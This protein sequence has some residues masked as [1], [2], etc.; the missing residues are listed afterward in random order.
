MRTHAHSTK[1]KKKYLGGAYKANSLIVW[2]LNSEKEKQN[3]KF[4]IQSRTKSRKD[5]AKNWR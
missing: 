1:S 4:Q 5:K 2:S 3:Q